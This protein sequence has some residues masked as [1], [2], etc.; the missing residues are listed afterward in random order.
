MHGEKQRKSALKLVD[1]INIVGLAGKM[2][3]GKDTFAD[4]LIDHG[5]VEQT[6][7]F[8]GAVRYVAEYLFGVDPR[9]REAKA[10][11][12]LQQVGSKMREIDY[13]VWVSRL[14]RDYQEKIYPRKAVIT[15]VRHV[16]EAD[17]VI[18]S[19]NLLILLDCP[20]VLRRE[21]ISRRDFNSEPIADE[22]WKHWH[23]HESEARVDSI[24][25]KYSDHERAVTI[26]QTTNHFDAN[27]RLLLEKIQRFLYSRE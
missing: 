11:D 27:E 19:G 4:W 24:F 18:S 10:R 20:E 22:L 16:N 21:R 17:W 26:K 14:A 8:A 7:S 9:S 6:M 2:G 5:L 12:I 1:G 13:G 15:D 3:S 23:L 25:R